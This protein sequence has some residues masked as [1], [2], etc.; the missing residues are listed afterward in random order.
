M[1]KNIKEVFMSNTYIFLRVMKTNKLL[2]LLLFLNFLI[3]SV[4]YFLSLYLTREIINNL[5]VYNNWVNALNNALFIC[6]IKFSSNFLSS[7]LMM[8][9]DSLSFRESVVFRHNTLQVACITMKI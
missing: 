3:I 6:G 1:L 9:L 2:W 4:D 5:F 8:L 7:F